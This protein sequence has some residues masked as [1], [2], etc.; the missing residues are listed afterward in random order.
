VTVS[1]LICFVVGIALHVHSV[2]KSKILVRAEG[3]R[4][5]GSNVPASIFSSSSNNN[6]NNKWTQEDLSGRI[7]VVIRN[8]V[9]QIRALPDTDAGAVDGEHSDSF[10]DS[11][12][13]LGDLDQSDDY[14][15]WLPPNEV[16]TGDEDA[17][18]GF[19]HQSS[20]QSFYMDVQFQGDPGAAT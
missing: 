14:F 16:H 18:L 15:D 13:G 8:P 5:Q 20:D 7:G 12:L 17:Q 1:T 9:Y 4:P 6:N 3:I 2:I 19:D 10:K 11:D